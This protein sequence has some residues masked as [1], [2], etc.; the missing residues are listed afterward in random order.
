MVLGAKSVLKQAHSHARL[1]SGQA[2]RSNNNTAYFSS[3]H[4]STISFPSPLR[5]RDRLRSQITLLAKRTHHVRRSLSGMIEP[6]CRKS[7]CLV[8]QIWRVRASRCQT[9][10]SLLPFD[11]LD[12]SKR[13]GASRLCGAPRPARLR[14]YCGQ[15]AR[16]CYSH[17]M[18]NQN[19]GSGGCVEMRRWRSTIIN[20]VLMWCGVRTDGSVLPPRSL[21]L[22]IHGSAL[23][24]PVRRIEV[25]GLATPVYVGT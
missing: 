3:S 19:T 12:H 17:S 20:E 1:P 21:Y 16:P 9:R 13:F 2:S 6:G 4:C 23:N 8:E 18:N 24:E 25:A 22:G 10:I 14:C 11:Q 7:G 5:T 15:Q